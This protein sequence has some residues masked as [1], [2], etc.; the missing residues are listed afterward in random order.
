VIT[1]LGVLDN[2]S[3]T[4]ATPVNCP[5]TY[6]VAGRPFKNSN[7]FSLGTVPFHVDFAKSCNT[8]FA[9]LAPKLGADGLAKA[10]A[11]VG[12]G[13]PW[14]LGADVYT[15]QV[16]KD[17]SPVDAAA[18]AF[19]QGTTQVSPLALAGA[20]AAVAH[21]SWQQ[22]KL[23]AEAPPGTTLTP[24]ASTTLKPTSVAALRS[25]MREVVTSGTGTGLKGVSGGAVYAKT[26]TAEFDNNPAHT[27]AWVTGWQGDIAFAVFVENGGSSTATAVPIAAAFLN[28]LR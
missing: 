5:Q 16:G 26:G 17:Q 6:T 19:G 22:P 20:V 11:S 12:I 7:N 24:A 13:V 4:P 8:A 14:Q 21:G 3:V 23:F 28:R 9:S 25:M 27:H 2:G 1:A 10:A 15:G 18:A